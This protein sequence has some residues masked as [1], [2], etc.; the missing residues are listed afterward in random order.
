MTV[1]GTSSFRPC[2]L[3]VPAAT[4]TF[5]ADKA[6]TVTEADPDTEP[7]AAVTVADPADD[8]AVNV[9][10][11]PLVPL[12]VPSPETAQEGVMRTAFPYLSAPLAVK[13]WVPPSDT[14]AGEGDTAIVASAPGSTVTDIVVLDHPDAEAAS[15]TVPAVVSS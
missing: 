14:D 2:W 6:E 3:G 8:P 1:N 7:C 13:V 10:D 11:V 12:I 4:A 15:V 5:I 9:V